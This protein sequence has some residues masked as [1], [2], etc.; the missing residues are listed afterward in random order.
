MG[1]II[2][3]TGG[4]GAGKSVVSRLLRLRGYR[5]YDCDTE[6]KRLMETDYNLAAQLKGILGEEAYKD[7]HLNRGYIAERI[8]N[9]MTTR[10]SVNRCVHKAVRDDFLRFA[11]G[12]K[13]D[14]FVE[15]AILATGGFVPL[16]DEIWLVDAPEET[17]VERVEK[18]NGFTR[19][20]VLERMDTQR[21]EFK[22]LPEGKTKRIDNTDSG[23]LLET[24]T[25]LL[26]NSAVEETQ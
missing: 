24:T 6:A 11:S 1:K 22:K 18:R 14:V 17:R 10:E 19:E 3:I 21:E 2:G 12:I 7:G 16:V 25:A 20:K 26:S 23:S 15:S 9:D 4:I 5:V 8:F 13:Q